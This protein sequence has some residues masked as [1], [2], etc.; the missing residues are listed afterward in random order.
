M[1]SESDLRKAFRES[2]NAH[3]TGIDTDAV[4]RRARARRAPKQFAL[5]SV[6]ALAV[7]GVVALGVATLP[8]LSLGESG[9]SDSGVMTALQEP[10]NNDAAGGAAEKFSDS[11]VGASHLCGFPTSVTGPN[12]A[13]LNLSVEFPESAAADSRS[14]S[15][16]VVLTNSGTT[17]VSGTTALEPIV[18]VSRG[19]ITVWH[20]NPI[21][22]T[23][24]VVL[25]LDPGQS[26]A[27]DARFTPVECKQGDDAGE[28]F[29]DSLGP[30]SPGEYELSAEIVFSP[31]DAESGEGILVGGVAEPISIY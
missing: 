13:G 17:A 16:S 9:A 4:V 20:S 29:P 27:F 6:S 8:S 25:D 3:A 23:Q 28:Q 1:S 19:G 18:T 30:L 7:A 12:P 10:P 11:R 14:V 26:Y 15:G 22:T 31:T 24:D 5:V 2:A 21:A